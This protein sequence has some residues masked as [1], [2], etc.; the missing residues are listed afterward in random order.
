MPRERATHRSW[1]T[2]ACRSMSEASL[3][4]RVIALAVVPDESATTCASVSA[5]GSALAHPP[6]TPH[7]L[8]LPNT[9]PTRRLVVGV[10]D[11][12]V[13]NDT[14][15]R[16]QVPAQR[17]H[18]QRRDSSAWRPVFWLCGL[19]GDPGTRATGIG[20]GAGVNGPARHRLAGIRRRSPPRL[21]RTPRKCERTPARLS[22]SALYGEPGR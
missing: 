16:R 21:D 2:R 5:P 19:T 14:Q 10:V 4:A 20:Q 12:S 22:Y 15:R 7:S 9:I 3:Q 17:S 1:C 11:D 13:G 6:C 8:A 18:R